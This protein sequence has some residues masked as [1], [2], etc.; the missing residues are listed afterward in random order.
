LLTLSILAMVLATPLLSADDK[1]DGGDKVKGLEK[2]KDLP[3]P[4]HPYNV[5]GPRAQRFHC[6]VTQG[7]LDPVV[8]VVVRDLDFS[9]GLKLLETQLDNRIAKNLNVRLNSFT[10]FLTDDQT[11]IV[12][13]DDKRDELA[14]KVEDFSKQLMLKNVV[15]CLDSKS[16]LEN[17]GLND[18][19]TVVLANKYKVVSVHRLKKDQLNA[20]TV[21]QII[22]DVA[23][24]LGA[25]RK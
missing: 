8:M 2:G 22:D 7:S 19:V 17:Y 14:G 25:T 1:P 5:T 9:E 13:D 4:F 24:Q 15:L 6:L 11:N 12:K 21:K 20:D 3:G 23:S 18:D 16:D 10:V